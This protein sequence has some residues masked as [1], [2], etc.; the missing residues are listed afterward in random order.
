MLLGLTRD[1]AALSMSFLL[2]V[3]FFLVF[4]AIFSGATGEQMRLKVAFADEVQSESTTR[5]LDALRSEA[6]LLPV[7]GDGLS[8]E[9][10]RELVRHGTADAGIILRAGGESLES[11]GGFGAAPIVI[12]TDPVRGVAA[13]MLTG[14]IQKAYFG[15]L[16]DIALGGVVAL[17]EDEFLE[18]TEEQREDVANS[19]AE[20]RVEAMEA[21][22]EGREGGW[23][24]QDLAEREDVAGRSAALNHVAY[25]A[26]GVAVLFLLFSAVHGAITLLEERDSGIMDRILAG[27][28]STRV[29]VDG[30]FLFLT[31][32][33]FF[34]IGVIF[35]VAWLSHGVDLPGHLLPW[36][37]TTLAASG[38]AAGI[39]LTLASACR[40][41]RQAQT[42]AN[43]AILIVSALGGSMVPRFFMPSWLQDLGWITPNTWALEAYTAIF[44]RDEPMSALVVP[45][46]ALTAAAVAGL[47]V[48]RR[49]ARRMETL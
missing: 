34:Q 2:P 36:A 6:A 39:A 28:G 18:L 5:L 38:A 26:G 29:L 49:L 1:R 43:V 16:P 24:F 37:L 41:R 30:K 3:L 42:F 13:P 17:L 25:Y 10:V 45:W 19:L 11:V 46:T 22:A 4:A 20:L 12:V 21:S 48:S 47:V 8:A 27:P 33:G 9:K 40:T 14:Q 23:D 31:L 15:A 44:W 7:G 35:V 32:Q